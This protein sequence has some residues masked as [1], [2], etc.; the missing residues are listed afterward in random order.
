[1]LAAVL[2]LALAAD[3]VLSVLPF[4]VNGA[5]TELGLALQSIIEDDLIRATGAVRTEADVA[6][7]KRGG[8]KV[9]GATY[10]VM[11]T[12][13]QMRDGGKLSLQLVDVASH[14]TAGAA[15]MVVYGGQ[16][17]ADRSGAIRALIEAAGL[18]AKTEVLGPEYSAACVTAW[19][20]ALAKG[21]PEAMA[22]VAKKWPDFGPAQRR[23]QK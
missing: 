5:T 3:P 17:G 18:T 6:A 11:G 21:T 23:L 22:E 10:L 2:T 14:T 19:G 1:M 8:P 20:K 13:V 7:S 16:W 9:K 4:K 15:N 12:L